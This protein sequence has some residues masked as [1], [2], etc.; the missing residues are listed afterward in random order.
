[1]NRFLPLALGLTLLPG[2]A[3]AAPRVIPGFA[4]PESVLIDGDRRYVSNIGATLD[5]LAKDGD[6]FISS[7][8][9][10]GTLI[11]R[12][13]FPADGTTLDAPK[14]MAITGG[15]LYVADI[16]RVIGFD[17]ATGIR[18]FEA[19]LPAGGPSLANDLAATGDGALLLSDTLRGAVYRL[20]PATRGWT[21]LTDAIPGANG[22]VYDA[23]TRAAL[24]AGLGADF[25]GGDLYTLPEG[26][27]ARRVEGGPHGIL[28]GLAR[29][30]D[31]R[32]LVSDWIALSPPTPGRLL[33]LRPDGTDPTPLDLGIPILGPADFGAAADGT[34]W[35]PA[36]LGDAV[37]VAPPS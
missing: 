28:D 25:S 20:D 29:L 23:A 11:E 12:H 8:G 2:F 6:G 3:A 7:L 35:I 16:D 10:D 24:V 34:L 26:G 19:S 22:I 27:P 21:L 4:T 30:P 9:A 14:G 36:T 5:P 31:G 33:L 32:L 15:R 17:I 1:M 37:V 18:G 13:A